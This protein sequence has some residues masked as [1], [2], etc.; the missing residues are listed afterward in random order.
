M[1]NL[2]VVKHY[3]AMCTRLR[4]RFAPCFCFCLFLAFRIASTQ[5]LSTQCANLAI[6]LYSYTF[7]LTHWVQVM[8][9]AQALISM[10]APVIL[11]YLPYQN[12]FHYEETYCFSE[13]SDKNCVNFSLSVNFKPGTVLKDKRL[14]RL[15][16]VLEWF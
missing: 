7:V 2:Y 16:T 14:F 10:H 5:P 6:Y 15:T 4:L 3:C 8:N 1:T 12:I 9:Y 13:T 11:H